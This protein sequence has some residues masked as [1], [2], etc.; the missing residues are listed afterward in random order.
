MLNMTYEYKLEPTPQQAQTFNQ[1]LEVCRKVWNYALRER[2]DWYNSRSSVINACSLKSEYTADTS[3]PNFAVQCKSLTTAR[4]NSPEL[5]FV[6]SQVLQQVL[7]QLEKAFTAMWESG[8]GFPRFKKQGRMK[9]FL[10]PAP[11]K[12]VV[13]G[14]KINL[15]SIGASQV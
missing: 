8:F 5:K 9:S 13:V 10:F 4:Q 12:T 3:R 2:K 11:N 7:K 1:W 14:N 6:H 15:P